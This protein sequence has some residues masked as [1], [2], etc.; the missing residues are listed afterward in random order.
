MAVAIAVAPTNNTAQH[1]SVVADCDAGDVMAVA[2]ATTCALS[3]NLIAIRF[4]ANVHSL[5]GAGITS[6]SV[7]RP[8]RPLAS[9]VEL[10]YFPL[11]SALELES[12]F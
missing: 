2:A 12:S 5:A 6:A 3:L 8:A 10:I 1:T 7:I 11:N 9:G 4:E